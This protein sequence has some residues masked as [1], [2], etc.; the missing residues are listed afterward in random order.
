VQRQ[1]Q[2]LGLLMH[3]GGWQVGVFRRWIGLAVNSPAENCFFSMRHST[4]TRKKS[5]ARMTYRL[6]PSRGAKKSLAST[7]AATKLANI[8]TATT[9]LKPPSACAPLVTKCRRIEGIL[10]P[11][12]AMRS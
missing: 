1:S 9:A 3:P 8:P 10:W 12:H 5:H 2:P 7:F 11:H 4:F 6:T